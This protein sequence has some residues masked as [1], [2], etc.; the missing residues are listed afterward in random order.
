MEHFPGYGIVKGQRC[1]KT[2]M[3]QVLRCIGNLDIV[4]G[5]LLEVAGTD[6][7]GI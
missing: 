5:D 6:L 3:P 2:G 7:I 4:I 1:I